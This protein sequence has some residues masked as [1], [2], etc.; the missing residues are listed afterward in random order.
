MFSSNK[1]DSEVSFSTTVDYKMYLFNT[2]ELIIS[3]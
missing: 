1:R 2:L 3:L